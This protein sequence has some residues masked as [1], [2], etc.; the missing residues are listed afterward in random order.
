MDDCFNLKHEHDNISSVTSQ[1][2]TANHRELGIFVPGHQRGQP[3]KHTDHP[4]KDGGMR[5]HNKNGC[6]QSARNLSFYSHYESHGKDHR[7]TQILQS[8]TSNCPLKINAEKTSLAL[9]IEVSSRAL[10]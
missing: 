4:I 5:S 10:L 7:T 9:L 3:R 8:Q 6:F 1:V 2:L